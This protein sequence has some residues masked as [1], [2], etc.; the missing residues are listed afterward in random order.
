MNVIISSIGEFVSVVSETALH[1]PNHLPL[2][3]TP[4]PPLLHRR[5]HR[6]HHHHATTT[7]RGRL[8]LR[9]IPQAGATDE[10]AWKEK[11]REQDQK[12]GMVK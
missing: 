3:T 7:Q 1:L 6:R 10:W 4:P 12:E 8:T 2:T 9:R 5:Q 11:K